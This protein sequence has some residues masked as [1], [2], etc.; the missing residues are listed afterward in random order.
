MTESEVTKIVNNSSVLIGTRQVSKAIIDATI[1]KIIVAKD[2]DKHM[3]DKLQLSVQDK[4]IPL[5]FGPTKNEL[6]K[7]VNIEVPCAVI[8]I[9]KLS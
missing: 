3:L 1:S 4:N 6:G 7:I 2:I 5:V 9:C 8:G